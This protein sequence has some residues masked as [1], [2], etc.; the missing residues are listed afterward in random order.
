MTK[1]IKDK[2]IAGLSWSA[3][4]SI[5]SQGITFIVGIVLARLLSPTEFGTI[6]IAMIFI[7]LFNKIVDCGFSNALIRKNDA[8]NLDYN[9]TFIFNLAL[10][11][12]LYILCYLGA[13]YIAL[14]FHDDQL[15]LV[16]KWM[17]L[18][19]IINSLSIIQ[20]TILIRKIDFKTQTKISLISSISSG[21]IGILMACYDM[22]VMSLVGQQL[23]RQGLNT[24]FLWVYNTWRP[25]LEFSYHRFK[26][27]FSYGGK[28]LLSGL[29]D[30]I[31]NE[32]ASFII[33]KVYSTA[34]LG[35]YS[36]ARQFSSIF[37]SN[38]SSI[39]ERVTFPVLAKFQDNKDQLVEYYKKI[40]KSLMLV[41]GICMITLACTAKSVIYIL[42]GEKW[43]EAVIYLQIICFNDLFYPIRIVNINAIQVCG[44][45]DLVLKVNLLKRI[46][47]LIPILLGIFN[48]YYMLYG[49]VLTGITGLLLNAYFSSKCIPYSVIDQIKDLS[50]PLLVCIVPA[51]AM[52]SVGLLALN[53][54][55]Q[56]IAQLLVGMTTF[57]IIVRITKLE[58]YYFIKEIITYVLQKTKNKITTK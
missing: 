25:K 36:R 24:L 11:C 49:L 33:G 38:L 45:S 52:I 34:T 29:V 43:A 16:L 55:F 44:R 40:I 1:S 15:V 57:F 10:S 26:E 19:V 5:A 6:G 39:M 8:S 9:T 17:S 12:V 48:I 3:I 47:Q 21:V 4:D 51:L 27:L 28:L 35:Q 56:L 30:V 14:F 22:G 32:S 13:P 41:C 31:F 46:I 54:Y 58:E 2:T 50:Q 20:R 37:S 53:I 7:G 42:V 23:S 18:V